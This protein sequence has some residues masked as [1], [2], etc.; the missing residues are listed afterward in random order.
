M[1]TKTKNMKP[2]K[3]HSSKT[4]NDFF[5][6]T[7]KH[8]FEKTEKNMLLAMRIEKAMKAKG[9]NKT[10][11]AT[12]MK[13]QPSVITKWLSGTHNFTTETLYDIEE[14]LSMCI[15]NVK[16]PDRFEIISRSHI[17]VAVTSKGELA[18]YCYGF[19]PHDLLKINQKTTKAVLQ[20]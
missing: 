14:K 1:R 15:I 16:E 9:F 17:T 12:A 7:D 11:F 10:E 4:L 2:V 8:E 18:P 5:A 3:T 13:V 6:V 20:N 19:V